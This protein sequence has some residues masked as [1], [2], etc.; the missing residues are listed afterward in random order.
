MP[1]QRDAG[2]VAV[3]LLAAPLI[4]LTPFAS[5]I[6][7]RGYSYLSPE[8]A[9]AFGMLVAAGLICG[10]V[11]LVDGWLVRAL[12]LAVLLTLFIDFQFE[13]FKDFGKLTVIAA[14]GAFFLI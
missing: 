8:I 14:F 12:V 1:E 6:G 2:T 4:L 9:L 11:M 10:L 13:W 5:F 7:F 3:H